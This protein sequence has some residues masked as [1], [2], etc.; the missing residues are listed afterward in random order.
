MSKREEYKFENEIRVVS[1]FCNNNIQNYIKGYGKFIKVDLKTLIS[2]III[3]PCAE[4]LYVDLVK[5]VS[6]KYNLKCKISKSKLYEKFD[7]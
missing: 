7:N 6:R 1:P 4:E 5:D 2:E 3:S